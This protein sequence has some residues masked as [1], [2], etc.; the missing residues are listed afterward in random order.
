MDKDTLIIGKIYGLLS[1]EA[2]Y[3]YF[4]GGLSKE[5]L[6]EDLTGEQGDDICARINALNDVVFETTALFYDLVSALE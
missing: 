3:S 1:R 5:E 2:G 4:I 6:I